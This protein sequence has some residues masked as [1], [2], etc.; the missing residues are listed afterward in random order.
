V[1]KPICFSKSECRVLPKEYE[2]EDLNK[3]FVKFQQ[4]HACLARRHQ[5]TGLGVALTK[6][7]VELQGGSIGIE[8]EPGKGSTFT[9]V[10]PRASEKKVA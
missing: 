3:L 7:I 1:M 5:G 8:S 9:V 2:T 6:K 4:L 10:I